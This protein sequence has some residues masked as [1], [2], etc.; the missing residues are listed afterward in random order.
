MNFKCKKT[1]IIVG[2]SIFMGIYSFV[3]GEF[4]CSSLLFLVAFVITL[5]SYTLKDEDSSGTVKRRH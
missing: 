4:V 3:S 5:T 1:D 2:L